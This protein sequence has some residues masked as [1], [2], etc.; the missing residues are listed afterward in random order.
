MSSAEIAAVAVTYAPF[1]G[2]MMVGCFLFGITISQTIIYF[3]NYK[4]D[5]LFLRG[6]VASALAVDT[7]HFVMVAEGV[8]NWYIFCKMPANYA[9]LA[10][11][12][13]SLGASIVATYVITSMVQ[14]LYVMRVW[15]LSK[16]LW[17]A[18]FISFLSVAQLGF[19]LWLWE[20]LL[21]A[22]SLNVLHQTK[23]QIGGSVELA[24]TT[25]C[26]IAI[27][28]ALWWYL[29]RGRTGFASTEKMIDKLILYMVNLG[30]L[31]SVA[32]LLTLILWLVMPSS[33]AFVSLTL[34]RSKLYCNAMLVTLNYRQTV[35]TAL[36]HGTQ[37]S[38]RYV[39]DIDGGVEMN[40]KVSKNSRH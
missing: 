40:S 28:A 24:A 13:W 15:M 35:R 9:G 14:G 33:F 32:S 7:F 5:S 26:D 12:H 39:H 20:D 31:T 23:G 10:L 6:L 16:N 8:H 29:H 2:G 3:R 21:V 22:N 4:D 17:V 11:F 19:G 38:S 25:L 27:S 18:I 34:I 36:G 37:Q 1:L 30:L